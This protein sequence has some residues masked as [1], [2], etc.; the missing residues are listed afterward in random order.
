MRS[1]YLFSL[2]AITLLPLS[3]QASPI[4]L[5][6]ES[7]FLTATSALTLSQENFQAYNKN[8]LPA[9][10]NL[11]SGLNI[12]SNAAIVYQDKSDYCSGSNGKCVTFST[13]TGGSLQTFTFDSGAVNAFG[14]FLGDLADTGGT[15]L[16]FTTSTG[17]TQSYT[18]ANSA[19][20][21]ERYFGIVD[22]STPF[23]S[24]TMRNSDAGD[25]VFIDDVR[26]GK[27]NA[28]PEPGMLALLGASL[29]GVAVTRRR[30][31]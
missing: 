9:P 25:Q 18:F 8:K 10:S 29:A 5:T 31:G 28:V 13:P 7:A 16:T 22:L 21:V 27:V 20:N 3:T 23:T 11:E 4:F 19:D 14:I 6:G 24:V 26:W 12:T 15:T 30:R 1:T 17:A 2:A